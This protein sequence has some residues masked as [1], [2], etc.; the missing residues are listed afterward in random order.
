MKKFKATFERYN[1]QLGAYETTRIVE[2]RTANSAT[3]KARK[4]EKCVYG[5]MTLIS[6]EEIKED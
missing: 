3:N 1:P 5:S 2:A 6:V 4:F